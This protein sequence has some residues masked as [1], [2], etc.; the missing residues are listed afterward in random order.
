MIDFRQVFR[1]PAV[2]NSANA[3]DA[4]SLKVRQT[5]LARQE[6]ATSR[7]LDDLRDQLDEI[8]G[9]LEDEY[10]G[11]HRKISAIRSYFKKNLGMFTRCDSLQDMFRVF[12]DP[13]VVSLCSFGRT[14]TPNGRRTNTR[15]DGRIGS[16]DSRCRKS[17]PWRGPLEIGGVPA[18]T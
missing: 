9:Q 16:P 17:G 7:Q 18:S 8:A 11:E 1:R 3:T 10:P 12:F 2:S 6:R 13:L 15:T 4:R 14:R 5:E